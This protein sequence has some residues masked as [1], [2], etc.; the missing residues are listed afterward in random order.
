MR[1]L[2][3]LLCTLSEAVKYVAPGISR[4]FVLTNSASLCWNQMEAFD[5]SVVLDRL[6]KTKDVEDAD[7]ARSSR[8]VED[9]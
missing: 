4:R 5:S 8:G 7:S 2:G 9:F 3:S 6:C 1:T